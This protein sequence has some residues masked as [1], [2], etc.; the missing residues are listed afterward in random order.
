MNLFQLKKFILLL[1]K[2]PLVQDTLHICHAFIRQLTYFMKS[3]HAKENA[4][5][6][7]PIALND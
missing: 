7:L 1:D 6:Q 4:E 2:Y 3:P 5:F